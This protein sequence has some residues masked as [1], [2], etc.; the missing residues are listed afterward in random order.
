[1]I[2]EILSKIE[3][4]HQA[5]LRQLDSIKVQQDSFFTDSNS[6]TATNTATN[7]S[8]APFDLFELNQS[9]SSQKSS[10]STE[11]PVNCMSLDEKQS[12]AFQ[13]EQNERLKNEKPLF[14]KSEPSKVSSQPK[15]LTSVLINANLNLMSK[16]VVSQASSFGDFQN[17]TTFQPMNNV[18]PMQINNVQPMNNAQQASRPNL[19]SLDNLCNLSQKPSQQTL[20]SMRTCQTSFG[21]L[22][23]QFSPMS[24]GIARYGP[25]SSQPA[26]QLS[27]HELDE[28]LN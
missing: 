24:S 26:K 20:N 15:D 14:E 28:F 13:R 18:Q 7:Q 8:S 3:E 4:E 21:N 10:P 17:H 11:K 1:M 2:R 9:L 5:K 22:G 27:K 12:L 6:V 16:P 25:Q 19:S 23:P